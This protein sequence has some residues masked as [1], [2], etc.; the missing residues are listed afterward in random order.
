LKNIYKKLKRNRWQMILSDDYRS[1]FSLNLE[2]IEGES[3]CSFQR[4][5]LKK[6]EKEILKKS[7][8]IILNL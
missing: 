2:Q 4:A 5:L 1:K 6:D 8:E 7:E 3:N